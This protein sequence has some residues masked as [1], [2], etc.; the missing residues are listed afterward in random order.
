M[1]ALCGERVQRPSTRELQLT[2]REALRVCSAHPSRFGLSP[3][4]S[5]LWACDGLLDT[6]AQRWLQP[7]SRLP[8]QRAPRFPGSHPDPT[9]LPSHLAAVALDKVGGLLTLERVQHSRDDKRLPCEAVGVPTRRLLHGGRGRRRGRRYGASVYIRGG[10]GVDYR[11]GNGENL[12][13]EG[14]SSC[15]WRGCGMQAA[16]P[17]PLPFQA[18]PAGPAEAARHGMAAAPGRPPTPPGSTKAQHTRPPAPFHTQTHP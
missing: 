14:P 16:Y 18:W 1:W 13:V 17:R 12:L 9:A 6:Y 8:S 2:L 10:W 11:Q 3:L 7:G 4:L 15:L 5:K